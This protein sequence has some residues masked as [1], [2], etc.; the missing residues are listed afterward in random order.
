MNIEFI[1]PARDFSGITHI[2]TQYLQFQEDKNSIFAEKLHLN[3][4]WYA[5]V[6]HAVNLP[7]GDY[8]VY[9]RVYF[10][11][12]IEYLE[13]KA[14]FRNYPLH[15]IERHTNFK[16]KQWYLLKVSSIEKPL[17]HNDEYFGTIELHIY[18]IEGYIKDGINVDYL[19]IVPKNQTVSMISKISQ[20]NDI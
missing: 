10:E 2:N 7:T 20:Y 13:S 3:Y 11:K 15:V 8:D 19:H 9:Y 12:K 14:S 4:V 18:N 6:Y 1:I 16:T 17:L 5:F